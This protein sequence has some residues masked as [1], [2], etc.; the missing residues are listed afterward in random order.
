MN[1]LDLDPSFYQLMRCSFH[2]VL[3]THWLTIPLIELVG[4]TVVS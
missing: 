1:S 4:Y 2:D 3:C